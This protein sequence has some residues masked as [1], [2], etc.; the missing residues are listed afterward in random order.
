MVPCKPV[1][2]RASLIQT[3]VYLI[4]LLHL[5]TLDQPISG[6]YLL[7]KNG[8]FR[9]SSKIFTHSRKGF[10]FDVKNSIIKTYKELYVILCYISH[11]QNMTV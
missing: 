5:V 9:V 8:S 3:L 11:F 4:I 2:M 6:T 1:C 10:S 7:N